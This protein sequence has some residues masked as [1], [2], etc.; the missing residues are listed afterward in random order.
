MAI[1]VFPL[2]TKAS[3]TVQSDQEDGFG[4]TVLGQD[5]PGPCEC[6]LLIVGR[7]ERWVHKEVDLAPHLVIGLVLEVGDADMFP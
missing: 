3:T 5:M 6:R 7:E 4:E 1:L 2:P